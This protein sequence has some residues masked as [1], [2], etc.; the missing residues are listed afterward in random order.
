MAA[1]DATQSKTWATA[2]GCDRCR[3]V[4]RRLRFTGWEP[5]H[6]D[7]QMGVFGHKDSSLG[8]RRSG[9]LS[10]GCVVR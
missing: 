7:H 8:E 10:E 3:T 6:F 2:Y 9:V 5:G 1:T 4:K